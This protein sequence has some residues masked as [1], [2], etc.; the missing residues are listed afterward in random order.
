MSLQNVYYD[1]LSTPIGDLLLTSDGTALTGVH[2]EPHTIG[3][4]W[5]RDDRLLRPA[6]EQLRA[7]FASELREFDLPVTLRGTDFQR[8][9]W[10]ELRAIPF[11]TAI[12]Y[13]ELARRI[14]QPTA[15]RAVGAANGRNPVAIIVPCHRVIGANGTLTGYGGGLDRK[16][17]LLRHEAEVLGV[18]R[19]VE[20]EPRLVFSA[21]PD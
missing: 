18:S 20:P 9:V 14:G 12:S 19:N 5:Q 10:T 13:G 8:R 4:G 17:W 1:V 2:M 11:G 21:A 16:R 7:Y 6:A 3:P 15:S